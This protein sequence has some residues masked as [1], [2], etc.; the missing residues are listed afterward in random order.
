MIG[1]RRIRPD[2]G[3]HVA[4]GGAVG[5]DCRS[6]SASV[7]RGTAWPRTPRNDRP[8]RPAAGRRYRAGNRAAN[9]LTKD[10]GVQL[11]VLPVANGIHEIHFCR[12]RVLAEK[13]DLMVEPDQPP[14]QLDVVNITSGAPQEIAVEY[15]DTHRHYPPDSLVDERG[16]PRIRRPGGATGYGRAG[17]AGG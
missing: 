3:H 14:G 7:A 1:Q 17:R 15:Q 6:I 12:L 2:S 4:D 16:E 13:V 8:H 9:R 10:L 5:R 11:A